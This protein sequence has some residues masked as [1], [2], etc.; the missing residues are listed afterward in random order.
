[1]I[2]LK[3]LEYGGF[4]GSK[5]SL[6]IFSGVLSYIPAEYGVKQVVNRFSDF[7]AVSQ[8][9]VFGAVLSAERTLTG[10]VYV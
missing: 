10:V 6:S 3:K 8:Q 7:R 1:M 2:S 9:N 5:V 4:I